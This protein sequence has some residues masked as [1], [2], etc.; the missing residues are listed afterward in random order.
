MLCATFVVEEAEAAA[1]TDMFATFM[2]VVDLLTLR[3]CFWTAPMAAAV[4]PVFSLLW[5]I[6]RLELEELVAAM[7]DL[8]CA[9][10]CTVV[11]LSLW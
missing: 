9:E 5:P 4:V 11:V 10:V 3:G 7:P 1:C 8:A 6:I 2:F